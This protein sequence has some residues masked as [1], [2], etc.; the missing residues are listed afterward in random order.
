MTINSIAAFKR[1][2]TVGSQWEFVSNW[3]PEPILR[4]CTVSQSNSFALTSIKHPGES[5]WC[6]WPKASEVLLI[7]D[8]IKPELSGVKITHDGGWLIYRPR[9]IEGIEAA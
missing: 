6:N 4:T 1:A 8:P 9:P 5:S 7:N 3:H 2:M